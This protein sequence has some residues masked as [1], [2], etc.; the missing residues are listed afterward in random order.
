MIIVELA[1]SRAVL[2]TSL[3]HVIAAINTAKYAAV[4]VEEYLGDFN[5]R[6]RDAGGV[7]PQE[8][9]WIAKH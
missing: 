6:V 2:E 4:D 9:P 7:Q 8:R 5:Q 1:T 3:P